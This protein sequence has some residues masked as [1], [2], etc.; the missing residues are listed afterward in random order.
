MDRKLAREIHEHLLD[1]SDALRSAE[2]A[3]QKLKGYDER[4]AF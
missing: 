4:K 2:Q 3:G 1:A